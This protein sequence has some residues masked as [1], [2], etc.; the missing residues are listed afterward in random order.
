MM[1]RRSDLALF[2]RN[3]TCL[4]DTRWMIAE[5]CHNK[6]PSF[7][8]NSAT[9]CYAFQ[10]L[11]SLGYNIISREMPIAFASAGLPA[12]FILVSGAML[13][14]ILLNAPLTT[15]LLTHGAAVLFLLWYVRQ[16]QN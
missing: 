2:C 15:T 12:R 11:P 5:P 13:P 8:Q 4:F 7:W 16:I 1:R 9:R 3:Q 10:I 14:Q 6:L